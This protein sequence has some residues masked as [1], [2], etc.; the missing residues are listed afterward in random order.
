MT[1]QALLPLVL[2]FPLLASAKSF[3]YSEKLEL[4]EIGMTRKQIESRF[5]NR[6]PVKGSVSFVFSEKDPALD[7]TGSLVFSKDE[8]L[9]GFGGNPAAEVT[10]ASLSGKAA[11]RFGKPLDFREID[12]TSPFWV[13]Y[14]LKRGKA[15]QLMA[16][17]ESNVS[18]VAEIESQ[19]MK[20]TDI[21]VRDHRFEDLIA[22]ENGR[23]GKLPK[24]KGTKVSPKK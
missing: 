10:V 19:T 17:I 12:Q 4:V 5:G 24:C 9:I 6:L 16:C 2:F 1:I 8:R 3:F 14:L 13:P 7:A 20:V 15:K 18:I 23:S 11:E 22:R 21:V